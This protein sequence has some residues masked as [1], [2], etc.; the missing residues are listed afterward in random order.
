MS[1]EY[2]GFESEGNLKVPVQI[3]IVIEAISLNSGQMFNFVFV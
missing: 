1:N 2:L 3:Q